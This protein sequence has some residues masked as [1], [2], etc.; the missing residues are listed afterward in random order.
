MRIRADTAIGLILLLF[1]GIML[2]QARDIPE[3]LF[4]SA[5]AAFFPTV[6]L[7]ILTPLSAVL[8]L[9]GLVSDWR[10]RGAV[11]ASS[12]RWSLGPW[13][14]DYRNVLGAFACFFL[15]VFLLETLGYMLSGFLF[16]FAMQLLLGPR[17]W[18]KIA[19]HALVSAGVVLFL[20][21]MF[22][23]VLVVLL[24]EGEIFY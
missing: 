2:H 19:Q 20:W 6:L 22:R 11:E 3:P 4:G 8:F 13:L 17:S 7:A 21:V 9:K 16:L 1:C 23:W 15:F 18:P 10:A 14:A 12:V 24:P 5:G